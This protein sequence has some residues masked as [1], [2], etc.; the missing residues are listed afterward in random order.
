MSHE[1][2]PYNLDAEEIWHPTAA[3]RHL[4]DAVDQML[5]ARTPARR[6]IAKLEIEQALAGFGISGENRLLRDLENIEVAE[7]HVFRKPR[8]GG[9][10]V[11]DKQPV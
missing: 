6:A 11:T 7:H 9:R 5:A 8:Q 2:G 1:S 3:Q 4:L 10:R